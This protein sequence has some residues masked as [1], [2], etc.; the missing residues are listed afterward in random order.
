[1]ATH[2]LGRENLT[3]LLARWSG[4]DAIAFE[5]LVDG[6]YPELHAIAARFMRGGGTGTLQATALVH[7]LFLTDDA[8]SLAIRTNVLKKPCAPSAKSHRVEGATAVPP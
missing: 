8:F 5:Q 3:R 4:G 1:M 6:V 7:D 2:E